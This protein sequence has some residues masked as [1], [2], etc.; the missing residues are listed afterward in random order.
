M[1]INWDK[2]IMVND[3]RG[4]PVAVIAHDTTRHTKSFFKVEEMG[5]EDIFGLLD[6]QTH[7]DNNKKTE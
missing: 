1:K 6:T 5:L 3:D 7:D 4:E 2:V